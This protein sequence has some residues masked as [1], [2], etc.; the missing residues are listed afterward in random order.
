MTRASASML[1]LASAL[2]KVFKR[3]FF[4][5]PWMEV[6]QNCSDVRYWIEVLC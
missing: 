4:L 6:L 2:V 3:L 5:N 1:A